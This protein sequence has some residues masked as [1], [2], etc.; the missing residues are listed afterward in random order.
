MIDILAMFQSEVLLS[1]GSVGN[2]GSDIKYWHVHT[3]M[4]DILL[5]FN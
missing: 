3:L 4:I 5:G 2:C 1:M